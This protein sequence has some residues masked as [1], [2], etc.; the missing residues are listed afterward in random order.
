MSRSASEL[1]WSTETVSR[2][3]LSSGG[4]SHK[5]SGCNGSGPS[6]RNLT[7]AESG[8]SE[9]NAASSGSSSACDVTVA[10][11]GPA[12]MLAYADRSVSGSAGVTAVKK[13][14]PLSEES[15]VDNACAGAAGG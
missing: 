5:A 11:A 14:A 1:L 6:T 13:P 3:P 9:G 2:S 12:P 8:S 15:R 7:G 10:I 4:I